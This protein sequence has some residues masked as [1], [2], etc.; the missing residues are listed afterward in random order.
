[1]DDLVKQFKNARR[2]G[3][4][5]ISI[6]TPDP[7]ATMS[8][9]FKAVRNGSTP[10]TPSKVSVVAWDAVRGLTKL[11]DDAVLPGGDP[12]LFT[13]PPGLIEALGGYV[14]L[15]GE[16]VLFALNMHRFIN[17][18]GISQAVWNVR[19][20]FKST[21]STL[22]LLAPQMSLPIELRDD[23]LTLDEPLPGPEALR[24][25]VLEQYESGGLEPPDADTLE[26]SVDALRGLPAY[27]AEQAAAM[28]LTRD[29][30]DVAA[31]WER[32]RRMISATKGLSV[33]RGGES[34]DQVG[35]CENIK[36]F[37]TRVLK[38]N[39]A[40]KSI[41]F[42]DEIEKALA[43]SSGP[44]GDSSGVS[45][46]QLQQ[47]LT[48]MQDKGAAGMIFIGP[49]GSA[50]SMVAKAAGSATG[51]P[52]ISLDLG[53]LKGSLVGESEANLRAA[54][55]VVDAVG[56]NN[57]LWISTCNSIGA[58]P[59]E[60]RRRF[61]FGIFFFDLPVADERRRIWSLYLS[62]YELGGQP[63]PDD[64]GWTG[65]EI[66]QCADIAWRLGCPLVEA[67]GY[68]VPVS[69]SGREIVESLRTQADGRYIS[70]GKP[71]VYR[72][73]TRQTVGRRVTFEDGKKP[74]NWP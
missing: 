43:G 3:T 63:I 55:K 12:L 32:K 25:I 73:E 66:R 47:L 6:N 54:L 1:M 42:V 31:L 72:L 74:D 33:W 17:D 4:P 41:V 70:A 23:V 58:L 11:H 64:D 67:A 52:V 38:G 61:G 39:A 40:P 20:E 60:L 28:S 14:K 44:A 53:G 49:P 27:P 22:V 50:K 37:L 69:R 13:G 34:F 48:Y 24:E 30:M 57:T 26:R 5:I 62:K 68:I 59:L 19:D 15:G 16:H 10:E 46:D 71:G 18:P 7:A 56:G 35:G 2:V 51:I 45:Q 8:T 65:A 9:L 21:G 36:G 29:G